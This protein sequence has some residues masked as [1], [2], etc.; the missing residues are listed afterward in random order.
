M[1]D[2]ELKKIDKTQNIIT[3]FI[4]I[5]FIVIYSFISVDNRS[6]IANILT[7]DVILI[8]SIALISVM[9]YI[10]IINGFVLSVIYIIMILPYF[11]G[12]NNGINNITNATN[13]KE[14][15]KSKNKEEDLEMLDILKGK[16]SNTKKIMDKI[17][18]YESRKKRSASLENLTNENDSE[19]ENEEHFNDSVTLKV[20]KF[21]PNSEE[22]NNL[23]MTKE[24]CDDIKNRITYEYENVSYLKKYISNKLQEIIDILHLTED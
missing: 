6:T 4:C 15:F 16:G 2:F 19:K 7:N 8:I 17:E 9:T 1:I 20:R 10:N 21:N 3:L 12:N 23:L 18:K 11:I 24:I 13:T 22:D 14:G 5:I